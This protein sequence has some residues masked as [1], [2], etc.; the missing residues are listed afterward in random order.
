MLTE[1]QW[2]YLREYDWDGGEELVEP[3]YEYAWDWYDDTTT[4]CCDCYPFCRCDG[5]NCPWDDD[6]GDEY[7][8]YA[9]G[10]E[11]AFINFYNV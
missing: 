6:D 1:S 4:T 10:D 5:Y 8:S 9:D 11:P 2:A 7:P 3:V